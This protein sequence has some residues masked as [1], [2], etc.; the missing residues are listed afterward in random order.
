M[1]QKN[2]ADISLARFPRSGFADC[3]G[4]SFLTTAIR[5]DGVGIVIFKFPRAGKSMPNF[6]LLVIR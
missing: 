3:Q 5:Y 6:R 2:Q 1:E 4:I